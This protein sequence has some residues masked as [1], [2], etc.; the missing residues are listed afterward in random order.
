MADFV[1][2]DVLVLRRGRLSRLWR[3][4]RWRILGQA[5]LIQGFDYGVVSVTVKALRWPDGT[6]EVIEELHAAEDTTWREW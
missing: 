5:V 2:P 4:V 3:W 1:Y 6:I